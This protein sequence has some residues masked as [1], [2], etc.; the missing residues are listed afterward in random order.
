MKNFVFNYQIYQKKKKNN[1][2]ITEIEQSKIM[3]TT[4]TTYMIARLTGS[5]LLFKQDYSNI[6]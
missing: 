6:N 1:N 4:G 2:K 5:T 3:W